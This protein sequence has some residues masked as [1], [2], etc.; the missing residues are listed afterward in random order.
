MAS[1]LYSYWR[2]PPAGGRV[3][4]AKATKRWVVSTYVSS[5]VW[6]QH[7]FCRQLTVRSAK[8]RAHSA[9]RHVLFKVRC[10]FTPTILLKHERSLSWPYKWMNFTSYCSSET[11][12]NGKIKQRPHV[13]MCFYKQH[14]T[15]K[16]CGN[17]S[18][19]VKEKGYV[20]WGYP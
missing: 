15:C 2:P 4:A 18:N 3:K 20:F 12:G 8:K 13:K 1:S 5:C 17:I 6:C 16:K 14:Q 9:T 10:G 19:Y 11:S 7:H